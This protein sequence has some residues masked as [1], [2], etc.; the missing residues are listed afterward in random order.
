MLQPL[1]VPVLHGSAS[2]TRN[3]H[4]PNSPNA[5]NA[6]AFDAMNAQR[7]L[8]VHCIGCSGVVLKRTNAREDVQR[9]S[10]NN[11]QIRDCR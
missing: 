8:R 7:K 10:G 6:C 4:S 2:E 3:P 9:R 1:R 11:V 5:S